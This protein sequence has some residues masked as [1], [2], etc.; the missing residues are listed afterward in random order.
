MKS[1]EEILK[2]LNEWCTAYI[3]TY[4]LINDT[5]GRPWYIEATDFQGPFKLEELSNVTDRDDLNKEFKQRF[6]EKDVKAKKGVSAIKLEISA[7]YSYNKCFV[8]RYKGRLHFYRD[9]LSQKGARI[10]AA[11]GQSH[12]LFKEFKKNLDA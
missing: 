10:M 9:D 1:I 12:G 6:F 4:R 7:M 11:A 2:T 5:G 3:P 8:Q